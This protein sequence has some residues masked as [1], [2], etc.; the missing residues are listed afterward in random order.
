MLVLRKKRCNA[1]PRFL[2]CCSCV[3]PKCVKSEPAGELHT[4]II[5]SFFQIISLVSFDSLFPGSSKTASNLLEL[6]NYTK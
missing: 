3:R 6:Y 4:D 2:F 5:L 1:T